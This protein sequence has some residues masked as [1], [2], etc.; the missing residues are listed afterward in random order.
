MS[1]NSVIRSE[2]TQAFEKLNENYDHI[3]SRQDFMQKVNDYFKE[4]SKYLSVLAVI[5]VDSVYCTD[6]AVVRCDL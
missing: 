4:N 3:K 2:D 5:C 1:Y 6:T